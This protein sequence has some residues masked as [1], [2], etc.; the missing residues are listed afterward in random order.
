MNLSENATNSTFRTNFGECSPFVSVIIAGFGWGVF[1]VGLFVNIILLCLVLKKL[2]A[3]R[4][5]DK[6]FLLIIIAVN[7][8]SIFGG[9]GGQLLGRLNFVPSAKRF[10]LIYNHI[11]FISFF[12]N[13]ASMAALCFITYENIIKFPSNR[14]L[15]FQLSVKIIAA[16]FFLSVILVPIAHSGLFVTVTEGNSTCETHKKT[17][18]G[19]EQASLACLI[20]LTT[21][22]I[23]TCSRIIRTSLEKIH[24]KLKEHHDETLRVLQQTSRAKIISFHRQAIA[25]CIFYSIFWIPHGVL[26]ALMSAEVVSYYSCAYFAGLVAA[27]TTAVSTPVIYLTIDKRFRIKCGWNNLATIMSRKVRTN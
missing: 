25:M 8:L 1:A 9:L 12:N 13:L 21:I 17:Y 15:D 16:N 3:G 6:L 7:L 24:S 26:A 5:N 18:T 14:L 10:C 11:L 23:G 2:S 4:R 27:H 19:G 20:I 22:W